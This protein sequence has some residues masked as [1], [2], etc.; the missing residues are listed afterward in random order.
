MKGVTL[1]RGLPGLV[2][3]TPLYSPTRAAEQKVAWLL[4][5]LGM[6]PCDRKGKG[7]HHVAVPAYEGSLACGSPTQYN[8]CTIRGGCIT[9]F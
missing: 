9:C 1:D 8:T 7:L 3:V 6:L 5:T 4:A 2:K